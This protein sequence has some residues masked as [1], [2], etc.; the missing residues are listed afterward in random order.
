MKIMTYKDKI[1]VITPT[2][3]PEGLELVEKAL[4]KQTFSEFNWIVRSSF[5][6]QLS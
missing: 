1:C 4:Y 5:P 3:R 6:P 2:I